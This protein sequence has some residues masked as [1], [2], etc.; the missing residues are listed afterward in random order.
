MVA[1]R[2]VSWLDK[3]YTVVASEEDYKK[4]Q[5]VTWTAGDKPGELLEAQFVYKKF[6]G[7]VSDP[8]QAQSKIMKCLSQVDNLDMALRDWRQINKVFGGPILYMKCIDAKEVTA[9]MAA[10]QDKNFKINKVLAGTGELM[11]ISFDITGIKSLEDEILTN[12]KMISGT[13]GVSVQ[14]LGLVELLKNRSTGDDQRES[15]SAA[16]VKDR[17]T[18]EGAYEELLSKAMTLFN[19]TTYKQ[20]EAKGQKLNPSLI[21]VNIPV[22]TQQHWANIK[23]VWLPAAIAGKISEELFLEQLPDIDTEEELNRQAKKEE[24]ELERIK[25]ENEDLKN[26][27]KNNPFMG[28]EE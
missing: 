26:Q 24:E 7:R 22:I 20:K 10:M 8:N 12:A 17:A 11:F 25:T 6:G 18:W 23:D 28:D 3:R 16:T 21:K 4:F 19:E 1:A 2:Y 5:K 15:L 14:H 9:A 13:T 27:D